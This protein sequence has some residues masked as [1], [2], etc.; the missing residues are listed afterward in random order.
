MP[1]KASAL[2]LRAAIAVPERAAEVTNITFA[3]LC[4]AYIAVVFDGADLRVRKWVEAFGSTSAWEK[5]KPWTVSK[6]AGR[7]VKRKCTSV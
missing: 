5:P 4:A 2:D 3:E 6:S 1:R 7:M